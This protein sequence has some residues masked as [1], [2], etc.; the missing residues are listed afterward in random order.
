[1]EQT[2]RNSG[3]KAHG[4]P[5]RGYPSSVTFHDGRLWWAGK[6]SI[7]GSV[8]DAYDSFDATVEGDS[9]PIN[10]TLAKGP[11]DT[12]SG[13]FRCRGL[14]SADKVPSFP[15]VQVPLISL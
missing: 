1:M 13:F 9:G 6:D 15:F 3:L 10:R 2:P 12:F 7:I 14:W 11:V 8:S 4:S 5:R